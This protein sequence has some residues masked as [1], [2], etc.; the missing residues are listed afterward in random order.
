MRLLLK[1]IEL[2]ADYKHHQAAQVA[3][4]SAFVRCTHAIACL[5]TNFKCK[6]YR[7]QVRGKFQ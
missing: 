7:V 5:Y 2:I 1:N 4:Y 6:T 3:A